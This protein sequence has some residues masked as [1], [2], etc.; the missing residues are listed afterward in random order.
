LHQGLLRVDSVKVKK[1][2][3][4]SAVERF[5]LVGKEDFPSIW[6]R[7]STFSGPCAGWE[8]R[9]SAYCITVEKIDR[10]SMT[11]RWTGGIAYGGGKDQRSSKLL[12]T[13]IGQAGSFIPGRSSTRLR[14][15][16]EGNSFA[17]NSIL[18]VEEDPLPGLRFP[19]PQP[20][21]RRRGMRYSLCSYCDC[22]GGSIGCPV[23]SAAARSRGSCT[24]FAAREKMPAVSIFV[25]LSSLYQD[26]RLQKP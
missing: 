4:T 1:T 20:V 8:A 18:N 13:G 26:D 25:I 2:E 6:K 23:P 15:K 16:R 12:P 5:S 3:R 21:E 24:I 22:N 9:Q 17:V 10:L 19:P 11:A 14:S 7:R